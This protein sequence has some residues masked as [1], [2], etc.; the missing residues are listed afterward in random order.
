G[1]LLD[2]YGFRDR[3]YNMPRT[4]GNSTVT[5][6]GGFV[7]E[8]DI[9]IW[10]YQGFNPGNP[11]NSGSRSW[12]TI[13]SGTLINQGKIYTQAPVA[14]DQQTDFRL[15][16]SVLNEGLIEVDGRSLR[17][18]SLENAGELSVGHD[19][20]LIINESIEQTA[21]VSR[22]EGGEIT[23][24]IYAT[25]ELNL[26]GGKLTGDGIVRGGL[27]VE[28]AIVAPGDDGE[29]GLL[30]ITNDIS[31]TPASR[32]EID[33]IGTND[34]QYDRITSA[35]SIAMAGTLAIDTSGGQEIPIGTQIVPLSFSTG[36]ANG[37]PQF[38]STFT[39]THVRWEPNY[40]S[41]RTVLE[42]LELDTEYLAD[43]A[44]RQWNSGVQSL[45]DSVAGWLDQIDA[46]IDLVPGVDGSLTTLAN[47]RD[48]M[49]NWSDT[50]LQT[51]STPQQ[52]WTDFE[53]LRNAIEAMGH[54]GV[55]VYGDQGIDGD[56]LRVN[57]LESFS[58]LLGSM[59]L[60]GGLV[61]ALQG[62]A[63]TANLSG[64]LDID[65]ILDLDWVLGVDL[66]GFYLQADEV[67]DL[68]VTAEASQGLSGEATLAGDSKLVFLPSS[69]FDF[70][71]DYAIT[72]DDANARQRSHQI[73]AA[74]FNLDASS[75]STVTLAGHLEW[76]N[77]QTQYVVTDRWTIDQTDSSITVNSELA[78]LSI[79]DFASGVV[80]SLQIAVD[81]FLPQEWTDRLSN[82]ALPLLRDQTPIASSED[83]LQQPAW[84]QSS[85]DALSDIFNLG[86]NNAV[87]GIVGTAGDELIH[88]SDLRSRTGATGTGVR[89]GVITRG[90]GD[91]DAATRSGD[92]PGP[93]D[94]AST[95]YPSLQVLNQ[96]DNASG[97]GLAVLE[98]LHD[99]AP[100]AQLI[101]HGAETELDYLLAMR[102]M[103][104]AGIQIVITDVSFPRDPTF[105]DG[106]AAA[107]AKD[108]VDSGVL[109]IAAAGEHG[110]SQVQ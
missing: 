45:S 81:Q 96:G 64:T 75:S 93:P 77:I 88:A 86:A 21:G 97:S 40:E 33:V 49:S 24:T 91:I 26:R 4:H 19:T 78:D 89:I 83:G 6:D 46:S 34:G 7:N 68:G 72:T 110:Q 9:R 42:S 25:K 20:S 94:T 108:L 55:S 60:A 58:S 80:E 16:G 59:G 82:V 14:S 51:I 48:A 87:R 63:T 109:V 12:L 11:A 10:S 43:F 103:G 69:R 1:G 18:E 44:R 67:I 66:S 23:F 27:D 70:S 29:A 32:I 74:A 36:G 41:N 35:S 37:F 53:P 22:L 62:L 79:D 56:L 61:N 92:L 5:V 76:D 71:G 54:A 8:G 95:S 3:F 31:I 30:H 65:L 38:E 99:V 47:A 101:Y 105:S 73:A 2:L 102:A 106:P 50:H 90:L 52:P 98:V 15:T 17:F 104:D 28:N 107:A 85:I 13:T 100:E 39:E 57:V 84:W